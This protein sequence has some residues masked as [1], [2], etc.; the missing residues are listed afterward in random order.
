MKVRFMRPVT[1]LGLQWSTG[2]VKD[3]SDPDALNLIAGEYAVYVSE[4]SN[5]VEAKKGVSAQID[6]EVVTLPATEVV[7]VEY[8][9]NYCIPCKKKFNNSKA[10]ENHKNFK[11]G[12]D[13]E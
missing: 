11:H 1:Y 7:E 3:F 2:N 5:S 8:P 4:E 9:P 6:S 10:L 12:T 13:K